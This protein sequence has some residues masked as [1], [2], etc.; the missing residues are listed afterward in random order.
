[1]DSFCC[2]RD[3]VN[4][5]VSVGPN[6][7]IGSHSTLFDLNIFTRSQLCG[8]KMGLEPH[9]IYGAAVPAQKLTIKK[10]Y[11]KPYLF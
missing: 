9:V 6:P 8:K 7:I 4:A 5:V 1:M 2:G 3:L 11:N 10:V